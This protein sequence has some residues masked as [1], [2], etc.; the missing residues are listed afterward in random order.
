MTKT[1][2]EPFT[3]N[4]RYEIADRPMGEGGMGVIYKA[5]DTVTKRFVAL[6]TLWA[7]ASLDTIELFEREWTV[8]A[9]LSHPNIVDI[10]DTGDWVFSGQRRPYFVMPLLPGKTLEEIIKTS[11]ERLTVE[12]TIDIVSQACRGLQAA[13]D[14]NL[15]HRDIKPSNIFVM[16]DD[17]VKIID[18]GVVHLT[19][20]PPA[21]R[22]IGTPLYMAPEQLG[23]KPASPLSD[24]FS[25]AVVCYETLTGRKPF[26]RPSAAEIAEAIRNHIP[27]PASEI[28][29]L[30]N[31]LVSRTVNKAMAKHPWHRFANAR[32]FGDT[33]QKALRNEHIERFERSKIQPRIERVKKAYTEGDYQFALEILTELESEEHFDPDMSV[34]RVQIEQAL[35]RKSIHQLLENARIRMEEEEYPLALHKIADV[36]A[37]DPENVDA[38]ALKEQIEQ[39]RSKSQLV[40][41]FRLVHEHLAN[42]LFGQARDGLQEILI[43]DSSNTKARQMLADIDQ[44]EQEIVKVREEKQRLYETAVTAYRSG[45]SSIALNNLENVIEMFRRGVRSTTP[46]LDAQCQTLYDS[47]RSER[48]GARKAYLEGRKYLV[49]HNVPKALEICEEYLTK[50]PGDPMFQALKLEAE[51]VQREDQ[52]AAIA[53]VTHR[54]D[55]EPDL[56]KKYKIL[57]EAAEKHATEPHFRS[58]L[59]LISDR[60]D[61]VNSIVSRARQYEDRGQF[62]DAASQWEILRNIYPLFPGLSAEVERLEKSKNE[63]VKA[64]AKARWIDQVEGHLHLGEYDK[65]HSAS[66]EALAGFPGDADLINLR[67]VSEQ[68]V[69]RGAEAAVLL[70]EGQD[71]CA[72]RNYQEGLVSLRKAERLDPRNRLARAALLSGL[73]SQ[74]RGLML[75]DWRSSEP[76][77][78]EA[79]DLEPTDPVARSL[80]SVL[81]DNRRHEAIATI[82]S[83]ARNY[84]AE[85]HLSDA[86][87]VVERGMVQY[88]NDNRLIQ[89]FTTLRAQSGQP[90]TAALPPPTMRVILTEPPSSEA[91]SSGA[92][93]ALTPPPISVVDAVQPKFFAAPPRAVPSVSTPPVEEVAPP[94][95]TPVV[96]VPVAEKPPSIEELPPPPK[97]SPKKTNE[98]KSTAVATLPPQARPRPHRRPPPPPRRGFTSKGPVW[99]ATTLAALAIL[100]AAGIYSLF[101][102]PPKP[103]AASAAH[104]E[105]ARAA[106]AAEPVAK[107]HPVL[108]EANVPATRFVEDGK[109]LTASSELSAGSHT[110]EASHDGYL[111]ETKN[112]AVDPFANSSLTVKFDL[113]PVL[114]QIRVSSSIARG[115]VMIDEAESLDLQ[116]G[117]AARDDLSVGPHTV[118]IYDGRK[119][120]FSFAFQAAQNQMPA[121][122]TPLS[123]QPVP[124]AVVASLA[125]SARVYTTQGLNAAIHLPLASVPPLGLA[126]AG[127]PTSPARFLL[128]T[129]K[130]GRPQ[131]QSADTS[132]T[133]TLTVQL[134]GASAELAHLEVSSSAPDC[135]I[136]VDGKIVP[137]LAQ[138]QPQSIPVEAGSHPVRLSCPGYQDLEKTAIVKPNDVG[139]QKLDFVMTPIPLVAPAPVRRA[140]FML[141]GAP[142]ETPVFQNQIRIGTVGQDGTFKKEVDPGAYTWEW[143][144]AGFEPR[145]ESRTLKAGESLRLEGAMLPSTGGLLLKVTPESAHL[146]LR[147]DSDSSSIAIQNGAPV[148]LA[149][150]SYRLD[151]DAADFQER[152]EPVVIA[153]GKTVNLSWDLEKKAPLSAPVRFFENG[154]SWKQSPEGQGW[155]I[156]YGSGYSSLRASTGAF[157]IDFLRKGNVRP[158]KINILAD[159]PDHGNCIVYSV[160]NHNF[161]AKVLAGGE[162]VLE[163]KK[164]HGM[165]GNTSF[166]LLFE[167]SPDAIVVKNR[168]GSVLST[169]QRKD[170]RGKLSIQDDNPLNIN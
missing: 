18:F 134:S 68:G 25:L 83:S 46:D 7:D 105:D 57:E 99:A 49:D 97:T 15:I 127:S 95:E 123:A 112:F 135:E 27:P 77:V 113:H 75:N 39:T 137:V 157:N 155:W 71:L 86:L 64:E 125:G 102:K 82:L 20:G 165:D 147:R 36:L 67:S 136:S 138:G 17:T 167:M 63:Q 53:E 74:A 139:P 169:V 21:N 150:G 104:F 69:K 33:L 32:E 114:S 24:M 131:L 23:R 34:L 55:A 2:P 103:T 146:S 30:V 96:E 1:L 151:A 84:Q 161:T 160:D 156:H 73:V 91:A 163:E 141:A 76:L 130:Q 90:V 158:K 124:G 143:R 31:Q 92:D 162:T 52:A 159:C 128:D 54:A 110:V 66:S 149:V 85:G 47:L 26:D 115:H 28:N 59:K 29:P 170:A 132:A 142:P 12:R 16:E 5:Y 51:E 116:S 8:L 93:F 80:L 109:T 107:T 9:R 42:N 11:S 129:G 35:R 144:K 78:K 50:H 98:E 38:H 3:V 58:A 122:V 61:L 56:D 37:L 65:A 70:K 140:S 133:P 41:W 154:G 101:H 117:V 6:K 19:D 100:L 120:V 89:L 10:L 168:A 152:S 118:K 126:I 44:T 60:R 153:A 88:P 166:H 108:F 119:E 22:L 62:D 94:A 106:A 164:P 40:N 148:Q 79:L 45:E 43:L 145:K 111:P 81:D 72:A 87:Q 13:H 14:Q 48:D 4:S 121:L